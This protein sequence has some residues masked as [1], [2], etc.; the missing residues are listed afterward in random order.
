MGRKLV[1]TGT[2]LTDTTAPVLIS[3]IARDT[4]DRANGAPGNVP[5]GGQPWTVQAGAAWSISANKLIPPASI[6]DASTGAKTGINVGVA[7]HYAEALVGGGSWGIGVTVRGSANGTGYT[8]IH[9]ANTVELRALTAASG[10]GTLLQTWSPGQ[11]AAEYTLGLRAI[12]TSITAY[13]NGTVLGSVTDSSLTGTWCG[14]RA[15]ST[16]RTVDNFRVLSSI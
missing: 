5:E 12:G 13:R 1:L 16:A 11:P 14:V 6:A 8:L 2:K 9:N 10:G 4:F 15:Q 7:N 3:L